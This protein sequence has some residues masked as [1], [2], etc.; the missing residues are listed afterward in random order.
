M[1]GKYNVSLFLFLSCWKD[2]SNKML[3][4]QFKH[5]SLPDNNKILSYEIKRN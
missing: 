1:K 4:L 5:L 2:N 3:E